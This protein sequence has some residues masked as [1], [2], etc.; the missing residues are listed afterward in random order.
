MEGQYAHRF[1]KSK[2][3]H[4]ALREMERDDIGIY[5]LVD[6][7]DG[8]ALWR[9]RDGFGITIEISA[10]TITSMKAFKAHVREEL[11]LCK[12]FA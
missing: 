7:R 1:K 2:P 5:A 10:K 6:W 4:H 12:G 9:Y 3:R 11:R 8:R